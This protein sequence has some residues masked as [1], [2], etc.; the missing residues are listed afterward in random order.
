LA[1]LNPTPPP[2]RFL[3]LLSHLGRWL[4]PS[5]LGVVL[6]LGCSSTEPAPPQAYT[7]C[8]A[9][10]IL[11]KKCVRCHQDAPKN[12]APFSLARYADVNEKAPT[13]EQPD[14]RRYE[15]MQHA[16][17]G[18]F[19]PDTSQALEPPV[20]ELTCEEKGILLAWLRD[21]AT[22]APAD[23]P[24]CLAAGPKTGVCAEK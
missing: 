14:R 5:T 8:D 21:G 6:V 22:A 18:G 7:Y 1:S 13:T 20:E 23:D 24:N 2:R 16:I 15:A 3:A 9:A 19:M 17:E 10:P 12:N 4:L 11:T